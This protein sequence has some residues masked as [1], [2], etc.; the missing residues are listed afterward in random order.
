MYADAFQLALR[1]VGL[2]G[3]RDVPVDLHLEALLLGYL[4]AHPSKLPQRVLATRRDP[5]S[6][7]GGGNFSRFSTRMSTG[8][9]SIRKL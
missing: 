2:E 1:T 5:V 9:A 6:S 3:G 4:G 7:C 8:C